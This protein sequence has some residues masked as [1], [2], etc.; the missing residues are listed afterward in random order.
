MS[1][2]KSLLSGAP[3]VSVL[4]SAATPVFRTSAARRSRLRQVSLPS[5][6]SVSKSG[7][8][9]ARPVVAMRSVMNSSAAGQPALSAKPRIAG[10]SSSLRQ[11]SSGSSCSS[12]RARSSFCVS[13][14]VRPLGT[15]PASASAS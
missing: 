12:T 5:T 9:A 13:P 6:A 14:G 1:R 15:S 4:N 8:E 11:S 10:S 3:G 2:M 7:G